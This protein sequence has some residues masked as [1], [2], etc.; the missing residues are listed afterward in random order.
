M[1]DETE[2]QKEFPAKEV[3]HI[4]I[5]EKWSVYQYCQIHCPS[6]DLY[7]PSC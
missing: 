5:C 4:D 2:A 1:N 6:T 3:R 7:D